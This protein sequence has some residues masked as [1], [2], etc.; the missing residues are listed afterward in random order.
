M[1]PE[2]I[3]KIN[4]VAWLILLVAA[5]LVLCAAWRNT[6]RTTTVAT[7][8]VTGS[9][10]SVLSLATAAQHGLII[11]NRNAAN[12][13]AYILFNDNATTPTASA[14]K[15]DAVIAQNGQL[16]LDGAALEYMPIATV[17]V[18]SEDTTPSVR[19][20]GW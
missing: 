16:L 15:Y 17:G 4:G 11:S 7:G 19:V 3:P 5:A 18:Y 12:K 20:V 9:A 14:T 13:P 1:K 8:T 10:A 2:W 6:A